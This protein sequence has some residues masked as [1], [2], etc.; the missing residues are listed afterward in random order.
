MLARD[1]FTAGEIWWTM[2][3]D[4]DT[5]PQLML[6]F[7]ILTNILLLTSLIAI[8]SQSLTKVGHR[9]RSATALPPDGVAET[10][11][12]AG[13]STDCSMT[14]NLIPLILFRPLRLCVPADQLRNARIILLRVTHI[15]YVVAIW[16]YE[17]GNRYWNNKRDEWQ[18][19]AGAHKRSLLASRVSLSHKAP[20]YLAVR[21][22][23]EASLTAKVPGSGSHNQFARD[24]DI[25]ADMKKILDKLNTQEEMIEK[26]SRQL[27][28]LPVPHP[29]S[30][31]A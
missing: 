9:V 28:E 18:Q 1:S 13:N 3:G 30:P 10:L 25:L 14:N 29:P 11:A 15:L 27:D 6:L 19:K 26:L 7:I 20:K 23:S 31:K 12:L 24:S 8:L 2:D 21:N 5:A 17:S 16:L 4:A 22:R